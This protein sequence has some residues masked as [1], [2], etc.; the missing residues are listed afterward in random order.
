LG[1]IT[2]NLRPKKWEWVITTVQYARRFFGIKELLDDLFGSEAN[3]KNGTILPICMLPIGHT[4]YRAR[5]LGGNFS[6]EQLNKN[7]AKELSAPPKDIAKAGRMNV[8]FIPAFYAAFSEETAIAEMRPGIGDTVAVGA[9]VLTRAI[10]VFDFTAFDRARSADPTQCL[11]HTRYDF[12]TQIQDQI[13]KPIRA[14]DR[15]REYIPTQIVAEYL[16]EQFN[17]DAVIYRSAMHKDGTKD[18]RNIVIFNNETDFIGSSQENLLSLSGH[19]TV[20][21][22]DVIYKTV[23]RFRTNAGPSAPG[24]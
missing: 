19:V 1:V 12:I 10:K 2:Q 14:L 3:Y 20:E 17:C 11:A 8:E 22:A 5:L 6:Y 7:P 24:W 15:P 4:I 21:I 18:N 13:S 9:F 23:K 16:R